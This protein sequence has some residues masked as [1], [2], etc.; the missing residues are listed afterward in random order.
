MEIILKLARLLNN[1]ISIQHYAI[2]QKEYIKIRSTIHIKSTS[3]TKHK[4]VK[5][6][7]YTNTKIP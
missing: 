7:H 6:K 1:K 5:S 4:H 2:I 3:K